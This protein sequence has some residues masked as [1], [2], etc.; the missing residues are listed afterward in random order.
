MKVALM[1]DKPYIV[2]F[3]TGGYSSYI[4]NSL[5]HVQWRLLRPFFAH[6]AKLIGVS[7]FEAHYFRTLLHLPAERFSVVPNGAIMPVV[8]QASVPGYPLLVT[9]GR[10]ERYK[11]Y[12]RLIAAL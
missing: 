6:A 1:T 5:R 8:E 10:L 2:T 12:H 9:V 11:G 3:H 4:R 7:Q